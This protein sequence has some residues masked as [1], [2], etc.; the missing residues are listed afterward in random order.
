[1]HISSVFLT[2]VYGKDNTWF[3]SGILFRH[4]KESVCQHVYMSRLQHNFFFFKR[5]LTFER[6]RC[7]IGNERLA[8][9]IFW[10]LS[11]KVSLIWAL[12]ILFVNS[13]KVCK[14]LLYFFITIRLFVK[15]A[16]KKFQKVRF[17]LYYVAP[18]SFFISAE[19]PEKNALVARS[20]LLRRNA[21]KSAFSA[22][23]LRTRALRFCKNWALGYDNMNHK[24]FF[25]LLK[26]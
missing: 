20:Y 5:S 24:Y 8:A 12:P 3:F 11:P 4:W 18:K 7:R 13:S 23:D 26:T 17:Q 21:T 19:L 1:M 15:V 6:D 10:K 2:Y 14:R 9:S 22:T 25:Y 16:W